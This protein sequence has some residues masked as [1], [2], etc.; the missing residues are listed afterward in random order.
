MLRLNLAIISVLSCFSSFGHAIFIFDSEI[1]YVTHYYPYGG[2]YGDVNTEPGLQPYKYGGKEFQHT[3]GLDLYD[4]HARQYDPATGLFTSMDPLCEKYYH[5]SPYA[6]CAGNPV[7]AV[8]PDGKD[9]FATFN[10]AN[11]TLTISA[12]YFTDMQSY[13]SA[14]TAT[15]FWNNLSGMFTY[16]IDNGDDRESYTINFDLKV[17]LKR[18]PMNEFHGIR[19]N[20]KESNINY[21]KETKRSTNINNSI[22]GSTYQN[23]INIY[24]GKEKLTGA[25]EVGH[26]LGISHNNKGLMTPNSNSNNRSEKIYPEDLRES[27]YNLNIHR[28]KHSN[29]GRGYVYPRKYKQKLFLNG[30]VHQK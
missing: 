4:F 28:N 1:E 16:E 23:R 15:E 21:Y 9:Y 20:Q 5:I 2:L 14:R 29:L 24:N 18:D 30:Q 7:N 11:H 27:I 12:V 13:N 19:E 26:S 17:E 25:H 3:H 22:N 10:D 8:D 6:Y